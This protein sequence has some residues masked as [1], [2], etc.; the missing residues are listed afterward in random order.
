MNLDLGMPLISELR[1]LPVSER[2]QL[3]TDLWDTIADDQQ[4]LQDPPEVIE[5]IRRRRERYL[6]NPSSGIPWEVAKER[7]RS[8]RA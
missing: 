8:R 1:A 6:Q 7:I 4:A 2:I 3:V 5:E